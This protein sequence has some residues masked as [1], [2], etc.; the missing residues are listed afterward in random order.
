MLSQ[1]R[2]QTAAFSS[3]LGP[4][5]ILDPGANNCRL[6]PDRPNAFANLRSPAMLPI[7]ADNPWL[8]MVV[9]GAAIAIGC[10]AIVVITD[11]LRRTHQAEI[12]ASLKH[13]M[14]ERGMSAAEI[15]TVLEATSDQEQIRRATRDEGVRLG[16]G[17]FRLEV[18]SLSQTHA[19]RN[20]HQ[21]V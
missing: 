6:G 19:D 1:M 4:L 5:K 15:K 12:D 7:L 14:L 21:P 8:V 13:A 10:T 9:A 18:G 2:R 17:D 11:Y 20:E 16:C 3:R